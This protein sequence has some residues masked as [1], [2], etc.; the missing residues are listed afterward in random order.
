MKVIRG[1]ARRVSRGL[2]IQTNRL[3]NTG[4]KYCYCWL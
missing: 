3:T 1:R 2:K 4:T